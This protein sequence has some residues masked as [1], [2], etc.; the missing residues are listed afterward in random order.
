MQLFALKNDDIISVKV[1]EKGEIFSCLE[2]G[3][4]LRVRKGFF[5]TAH[6]YHVKENIWCRQSGKGKDHLFVQTYLLALLGKKGVMERRFNSIRRIADIVWESKKII[7][8]IQCSP[9]CE[10]EVEAREQDYRSLGYAIVWLLKE[11][12]FNRR[13]VSG[14]EMAMRSYPSIF[15]KL[16][17]NKKIFF[18][19]QF[20]M[21]TSSKRSFSGEKCAVNPLVPMLMPPLQR[22]KIKKLPNFIFNRLKA[23]PLYFSGDLIDL[24]LKDPKGLIAFKLQLLEDNVVTDKSNMLLSGLK[25]CYYSI[26]AR[27]VK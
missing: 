9:I 27:F 18:Y 15:F 23:H 21:F 11:G 2:C 12:V 25:N 6:F 26:L 5:K 10:E 16:E 1:A 17:K 24:M 20:E 19:D 4:P 7:F 13:K 22:I 8:E 3:E 14:G